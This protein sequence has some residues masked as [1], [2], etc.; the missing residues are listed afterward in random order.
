MTFGDADPASRK[1]A[2]QPA[3]GAAPPADFPP[4]LAGQHLFI[5]Y[6]WPVGHVVLAAPAGLGVLEPWLQ[7]NKRSRLWNKG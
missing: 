7:L 6:R 5:G 1:E 3:F 4:S 2:C